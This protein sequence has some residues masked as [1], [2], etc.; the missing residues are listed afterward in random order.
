MRQCEN[1][2]TWVEDVLWIEWPADPSGNT[3]IFC[4]CAD[5]LDHLRQWGNGKDDV[6]EI[7][8]EAAQRD[9]KAPNDNDP[10]YTP[11]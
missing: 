2:Q 9:Y 5:C 1:C 11:F 7:G 10:S 6:P 8:S 4:V 3:E